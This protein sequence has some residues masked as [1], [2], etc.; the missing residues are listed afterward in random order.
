VNYIDWAMEAMSWHFSQL[1][2][3]FRLPDSSLL[4]MEDLSPDKHF[5]KE[6]DENFIAPGPYT[7]NP[8]TF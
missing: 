4:K 2:I 3:L 6:D 1:C 8:V 7:S 5:L